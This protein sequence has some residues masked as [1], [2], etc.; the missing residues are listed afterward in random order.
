M[1][2]NK[3]GMAVVISLIVMALAACA[4]PTPTQTGGADATEAPTEAANGATLSGDVAVDGSSTVFPLMTAAVEEYNATQPDV[5]VSVGES[6]TGGGFKKF[7]GIDQSP[8]TD[9]SDASRAIKPEEA[10]ACAKAGVEYVELLVAYDGLTVVVN[11]ANDYAECLDV[12]Q[13]GQL[14]RP[15]DAE[16][17]DTWADLDPAWPAEPIKF[18]VPDPDSGTRDFFIEAVI[19]G[20]LKLEGDNA[21][22]RQDDNTSFSSDDNVLLQGVAGEEF[23]LGFFGYAYYINNTDKVKAVAIKNKAGECVTPGSETVQDGSY[24][25]LSRPLYI[26]I[27]KASLTDK[28]QVADLVKYLLSEDG[29]PLVMEDVGYSLPP[30]GSY[31]DGLAEVEAALK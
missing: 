9:I 14:F 2:F 20:G 12:A 5:R 28:P 31:A 8:S 18:F 10:D 30:E 24:N 26:Y 16:N 23:G 1:G 17:A 22:I 4:A 27:N 3:L 15:E 13:L 19:A 29:F 25:P 7:C 11:P 21:N 6:G